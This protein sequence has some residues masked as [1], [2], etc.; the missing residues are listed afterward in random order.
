MLQRRGH[1]AVELSLRALPDLPEVTQKV[2]R[3]LGPGRRTWEALSNPFLQKPVGPPL[4]PVP[5]LSLGT[6]VTGGVQSWEVHH[7]LGPDP[8]QAHPEAFSWE[9]GSLSDG[10][11]QARQAEGLA[12]GL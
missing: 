12:F 5:S 2:S 10:S 11:S 9:R 7:P 6:G 4:D 8:C 3:C 1:Q